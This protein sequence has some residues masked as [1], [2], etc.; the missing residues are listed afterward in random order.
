MDTDRSGKCGRLQEACRP[1][2]KAF[3]RWIEPRYLH[4]S[5]KDSTNMLPVDWQNFTGLV[6]QAQSE[7]F[8]AAAFIHGTD[9]LAFSSSALALALTGTDPDRCHQRI[10]VGITG[11]QNS[12]YVKGGDGEFN[13]SNLLRIIIQAVEMRSNEVL[14]NFWD[15]VYLGSRTVKMSPSAFLAFDSPAFPKVGAI[16]AGGVHLYPN[17]LRTRQPNRRGQRKTTTA[18]LWGPGLLVLSVFPGMEPILVQ[19]ILDSGSVKCVIF[20]CLGEGNICDEAAYSMIPV[21]ERATAQGTPCIVSSQF[22][23]GRAAPGSYKV[24]RAVLKAGG[25]PVYDT[26][27]PMT[28]V[29]AAWALGNRLC[30]SVDDWRKFFATPIANEVTPPAPKTRRRVVQV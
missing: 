30:Q 17:L 16:D 18:P 12:I 15:G 1:V 3:D 10:P 20:E 24:G 7:G 9:S 19:G 28:I 21:I 29:K 2:L 26:T 25:V 11:A 4:Y 27:L 13:L 8:D 6:E 5:S 23:G 22:I 14:V